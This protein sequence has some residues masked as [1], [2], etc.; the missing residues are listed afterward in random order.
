MS[1]EGSVYTESQGRV[2]ASAHTTPFSQHSLDSPHFIHHVIW[3]THIL[4]LFYFM[5]SCEVV[6]LVNLD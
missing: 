4:A 6:T 2:N 5:L 1:R 3:Q